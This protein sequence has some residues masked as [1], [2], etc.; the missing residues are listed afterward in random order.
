METKQTK[1]IDWSTL[2]MGVVAAFALFVLVVLLGGWVFSLSWNIFMVGA[3][4]MPTITI[5]EGVNAI[6][7]LYIVGY[8][9]GFRRNNTLKLK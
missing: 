4:A 3:F 5:A 1:Q 8:V 6:V 2:L 7:I 9:L